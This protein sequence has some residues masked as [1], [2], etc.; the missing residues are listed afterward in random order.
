M[1]ASTPN[2][3]ALPCDTTHVKDV[4]EVLATVQ[5]MGGDTLKDPQR[6]QHYLCL[7]L[8]K[9]L[10][11]DIFDPRQV[12]VQ[13]QATIVAQDNFFNLAFVK[14]NNTKPE[15]WLKDPIEVVVMF[16]NTKIVVYGQGRQKPVFEL[17]L[18]TPVTSLSANILAC[19]G[20]GQVAAKEELLTD[21]EVKQLELNVYHYLA[22]ERDEPS[23]AFVNFLTQMILRR[24][25]TKE[26][27]PSFQA[28]VKRGLDKC[29]SI[30]RTETP[31]T[32][33]ELVLVEVRK[34]AKEVIDGARLTLRRNK[35]YTSILLDDNNRRPVLRLFATPE[36]T[37]ELALGK[38]YKKDQRVVL[39][40]TK[41][42]AYSSAIIDA[43]KT[44]MRE[45][46]A[47]A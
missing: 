11:Y 43:I 30:W 4:L 19:L 16:S 42:E 7:N 44:A 35:T 15:A 45:A 17:D 10:G 29:V 26:E 13:D 8:V 2:V 3:C 24:A 22:S 14:D 9:A 37:M 32:F 20:R 33:E 46:E 47:E 38:A 41:L 40:D 28:A 31:P 34:L 36:G 25:V 1:N 6:R 5:K 12:T 23:K 39:K 21:G 27:L 18:S